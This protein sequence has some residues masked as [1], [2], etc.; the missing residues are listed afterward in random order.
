[1]LEGD[2]SMRPVGKNGLSSLSLRLI[3]SGYSNSRKVTLGGIRLELED[4]TRQQVLDE[5]WEVVIE[6]DETVDVS[7]PVALVDQQNPG[8]YRGEIQF[9]FAGDTSFTPAL[10]SVE[11]RVKGFIGNNL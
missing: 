2:L 5:Q 8:T 1:M 10:A 3:S 7:I 11:Y 6:P 4:G 9:I